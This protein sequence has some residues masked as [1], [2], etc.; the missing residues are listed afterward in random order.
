MKAPG[1]AGWLAIITA[2]LVTAAV[3]AVSI[4]G[5]RL[6]RDLAE[7]EALARVELGAA[8]AREELRQV[9]EAC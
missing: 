1:L 2:F 7:A 6:L 3:S 8:A 4:A 9:S 5:I